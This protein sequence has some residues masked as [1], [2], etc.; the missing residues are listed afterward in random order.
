MEELEDVLDVLNVEGAERELALKLL[1][2]TPVALRSEPTMIPKADALGTS[3]GDIDVLGEIL[4]SLLS[5]QRQI[6]A[7]DVTLSFPIL[8]EFY[9]D[10]RYESLHFVIDRTFAQFVAYV[11]GN[12]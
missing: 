11:R 9:W 10:E 3:F 7:G 12:G 1:T 5:K 2:A 4:R 8:Q 6:K